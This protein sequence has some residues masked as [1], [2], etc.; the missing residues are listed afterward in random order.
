MKQVLN[1]AESKMKTVNLL[2]KDYAT[3][4]RTGNTSSA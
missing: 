1:Q 2:I 3:L 4:R